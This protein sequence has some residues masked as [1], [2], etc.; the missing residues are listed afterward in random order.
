MKSYYS[1]IKKRKQ[2]MKKVML[3]RK[4]FYQDG[5]SKHLEIANKLI[6]KLGR[7]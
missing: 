7:G 1:L 5:N 2:K 6:N 4:K 3:C